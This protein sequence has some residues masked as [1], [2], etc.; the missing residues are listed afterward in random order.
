MFSPSNRCTFLFLCFTCTHSLYPHFLSI[1]E[2]T[3]EPSAAPTSP[4][5]APSHVP[6]VMPTEAPTQASYC[7]NPTQVPAI[8]TFVFIHHSQAEWALGIGYTHAREWPYIDGSSLTVCITGAHGRAYCRPH[9][10]PYLSPKLPSYQ[11]N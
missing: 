10:S 7:T 1:Q 4:T 9:I 8:F 3:Q 11:S 5:A 2:P 6:T